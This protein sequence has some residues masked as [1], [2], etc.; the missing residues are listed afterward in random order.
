MFFVI[1]TKH[2]RGAKITNSESRTANIN[3]HCRKCGAND[4]PESEFHLHHL[5]PK[6]IGGTDTQGRAYLCKSC[7]NKLHQAIL[8]FTLEWIGDDFKERYIRFFK[9]RDN[10]QDTKTITERAV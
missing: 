6:Y 5:V 8:E 1:H 10:E 9:K 4:L 7:H 2:F 3:I